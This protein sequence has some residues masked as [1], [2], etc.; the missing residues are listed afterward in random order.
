MRVLVIFCAAFAAGVALSQY[1]LSAQWALILCG[2]FAAAA[3][4]MGLCGCANK[5]GDWAKRAFLCALGLCFAFGYNTLYAHFIK[6]PND[7]LL[8]TQD[9]VEVELLGYAE[10]TSHGAKVTVKILNR[11]LPGRAI[12][13]GDADLMDLEPG[14]HVTAE[15][16][17]NSATDPTGKG[18]HLR[19]FTAKG[20]YILLYQRGD[21]TYDDTNAG[22]L[23]Y[24]PQRI[25]RTLGETIE[26]SYSE[27][28]GAFLRALLLGD[29]KYLDEEDASNLSEVGL[30]HVMAVSGLHCC[31][32]A[33]LIG[34]LMGDRRKKLRCA[35][36]IPLIFLYAFVT[37]LTP[38][39]LRACI[40]ISMGMIA[41]LLGRDNDPPTSISFALLLIL[42]KNPFAIASISLQL[43]FSA[44]SGIIWL[45]P[46]L[47]KRAHGK[48]KLVRAALLSFSTTL[49][50]MVFST[51]LA[52]YYF[53]TLSIVSLLSNLLCRERRVRAGITFGTDRGGCAAARRGL[54]LCASARH[55]RRAC[56]RRTFGGA[57]VP[58][59]LFQ[60]RV[61]RRMACVRVRDLHHLRAGKAREV[62]LF[63]G[64]GAF[65]P[66]AL[67]RGK[68]QCPTL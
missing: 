21:P 28:D 27:R 57:S 33:S 31:F 6:A 24:L 22:A 68:G 8:G 25:A 49:G 48:H 19:N 9:T 43:S 18:L 65:R 32:L 63:C 61:F 51:P 50:A 14:A 52:C 16:L 20:V 37:G 30:S 13:Y 66:V 11:G 64:G 35:V 7:A 40:M 67:R 55:S 60:H 5:R 39:I 26:R 58:R 34:S 1:L 59:H 53:G 4:V 23:K 47:T 17:F 41:P 56:H 36:T 3:L 12:Y 44:V 42:L 54:C 15:A 2:V 62:P 45:T 29:K 46:K 10:E 38:S